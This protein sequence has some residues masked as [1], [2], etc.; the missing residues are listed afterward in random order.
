MTETRTQHFTVAHGGVITAC[1]LALAL[2]TVS[3]LQA[4][5]TAASGPE[6]VQAQWD[7]VILVDD[8]PA[9]VPQ[10]A[11]RETVARIDADGRVWL[12][13]GTTR[14][15]ET[16]GPMRARL[17][18]IDPQGLVEPEVDVG[19]GGTGYH[20]DPCLGGHA[21]LRGRS[22]LEL[23]RSDGAVTWDR[24]DLG[25]SPDQRNWQR[26]AMPARN[27]RYAYVRAT[28]AGVLWPTVHRY[29]ALRQTDGASLVDYTLANLA[30]PLGFSGEGAL[31]WQDERRIRSIDGNGEVTELAS[32]PAR[33][34]LLKLSALPR[35]DD[36]LFVLESVRELLAGESVEPLNLLRIDGGA[37]GWRTRLVGYWRDLTFGSPPLPVNT[38][39]RP[40]PERSVLVLVNR[41]VRTDAPFQVIRELRL[42]RVADSG[43][44]IWERQILPVQGADAVLLGLRGDRVVVSHGLPGGGLQ[45]TGLDV[46]DG[47][48]VAAVKFTCP[49]N[50]C[51]A[52]T[53]SL[54]D[55]GLLH[56]VSGSRG[57]IAVLRHDH[58]LD[59]LPHAAFDPG[60]ANAWASPRTDGQGL[61]VRV[62]PRAGGGAT[63][64]APW[65]T[66]DRAGTDGAAS[67]RWYALQGDVAADDREATLTIVERRGGVFAAAPASPPVVVGQARLRFADCSTGLLDYRFD[68][69]YNG[70]AEGSVALTPL[71]PRG[72][73][74][75]QADGQALPAQAE[76][77]PAL[78]GHWFDPDRP[79][80]GLELA[81]I[82]PSA[83]GDGLLYGA[84]FTFDPAPANDEPKDQHWFTVQGQ[85]ARTGGGVRTTIVQTL[86]GRFDSAPAGAPFRVGE[87][88]L[89]PGPDCSTLTLSYRFDDTDAAGNFR[90]GTGQL[91]LRRLGACPAS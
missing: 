48:I 12:L 33:L 54:D 87:A 91:R 49:A 29:L 16:D 62:F 35:D 30:T 20:L 75:T 25:N 11:A 67:L 80:Q 83:T 77:D 32:L 42:H 51:Q 88:D 79:G 27:G 56:V 36:A 85:E 84:W 66:F 34:N 15:L 17:L 46:A 71:L 44:L 57:Q 89:L 43:T 39:V 40:G 31:L 18:T 73:P 23:R 26:M 53:A 64:L 8:A 2:T 78:T 38:Q 6:P 45:V 28:N 3:P 60:V 22:A 81:R 74:C 59:D 72:A 76:Y 24:P 50:L 55:N 21:C 10:A 41:R 5:D 90:S 37:I 9:P 4:A 65:F 47:R 52:H 13:P 63:I 86:G 7:R 19:Q 14:A 1:T 69:D 70:G 61:T 68:P 82:A 58:V